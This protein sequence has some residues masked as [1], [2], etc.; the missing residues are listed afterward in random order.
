MRNKKRNPGLIVALA[1]AMLLTGVLCT[2]ELSW[3]AS[4]IKI[5]VVYSQSGALARNGNLVVQGVKAA[6]GWVNENGGIK[7]LGGAKLK[8]VVVDCGSSVEGAASAME[9]VVR[10]PKIT[11]VMGSWASSFTMSGTEITERLEIPQFT[12]SYSDM[13]NVRGFKWGFYVVP[14]SSA[15]AKLGLGAEIDLARNAGQRVKTAMFV[16]DNQAASKAFYAAVRKLF[17]GMGINIIKEELWA[18]GTLTDATPVLQ[19]VKALDPDIVV[20]MATA[21]SEAQM[22]LMKKRELGIEIPFI[23]NGGWACDPSFRQVGAEFLEGMV[24]ITP[25]YPNRVTPKEWITRS[26]TQCKK[27]YSDEPWVG[28]ELGYA[29]GM[30]PIMAEVLERTGSKDRHAIWKVARNLDIHDI[31]ATQYT[32]KQGIAFDENGRIAEKYQ[33]VMLVQW[34]KGVPVC[35]YPRHLAVAEPIWKAKK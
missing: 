31:P 14:P 32:V 33:G 23:S 8:P 18:M 10:D 27:E 5:G 13:L 9:R 12:I 28:Q 25:L 29:W 15:Q 21:I 26:L 6:M 24:T 7:S 4:D 3:A 17:P 19:K 30:V 34:Q 11:M 35:I 1:F 2:K 20:F 22:C 16:G